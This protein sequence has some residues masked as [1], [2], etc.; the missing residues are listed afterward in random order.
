MRVVV[1][2]LCVVYASGVCGRVSCVHIVRSARCGPWARGAA[3]ALKLLA[4]LRLRGCCLWLWRRAVWPHDYAHY[5][6]LYTM[7]ISSDLSRR[8]CVRLWA[9]G[10]CGG[11][12]AAQLGRRR[13][14]PLS[15]IYGGCAWRLCVAHSKADIIATCAHAILRKQFSRGCVCRVQ[16]YQY[17]Y[18]PFPQ[19]RNSTPLRLRQ[20]VLNIHAHPRKVHSACHGQSPQNKSIATFKTQKRQPS[21]Q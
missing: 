15:A 6:L 10:F 16:I 14:P 9:R 4:L 8:R 7:L 17:P 12:P 1:C 2:V 18:V 3:R 5:T 20:S 19:R 11:G 13:P 21:I